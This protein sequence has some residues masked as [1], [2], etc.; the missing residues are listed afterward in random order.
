MDRVHRQELKHDRFVEQVGHT[1][2][3]AAEHKQQF[4]RYAVI[5]LAAV[6][7]ILGGFWYTRHQAGLRQDALRDAIRTQE[8]QVGQNASP[9]FVTFPTDAEKQKAVDKAWNDLANN[10]SGSAE[11]AIAHYYMGVN[12]SDRGNTQEAEKQFKLAADSGKDDYASQAKLALASIYA[13][14]GRTDEAEKVLR[15]VMN[16]PTV[17]VSKEAAT[18]ELARVIAKSKPAEARKLL[19][20]LRTERGPVSRAALTLLN[21]IPR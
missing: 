19:E 8:A 12:A 5:G 17:L 9:F 7:L 21:E 14:S 20:P 18:I 6:V 1:V 2:E 11:A 16:D 15:S 13:S 3:F 10:H 4:V